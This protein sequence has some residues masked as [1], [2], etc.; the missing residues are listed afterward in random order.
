MTLA[1]SDSAGC[2]R[3]N[4]SWSGRGRGS[5]SG[6]LSHED[7]SGSG[8]GLGTGLLDRLLASEVVVPGRAGL[9]RHCT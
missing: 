6:W 8:L 2:R 1:G 7:R 4:E 3:R 9:W 5:G